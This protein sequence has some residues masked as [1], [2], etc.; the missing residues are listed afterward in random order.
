MLGK[1]HQWLY[2]FLYLREASILWINIFSYRTVWHSVILLLFHLKILVTRVYDWPTE[3]NDQLQKWLND[4]WNNVGLFLQFYFVVFH[5]VSFLAMSVVY[6]L[7]RTLILFTWCW[8]KFHRSYNQVLVSCIVLYLTI[9]NNITIQKEWQPIILSFD[10]FFSISLAESPPRD[11]QITASCIICFP[12]NNILL[13]RSCT[14][15]VRETGISLSWV[16][17]E[18]SHLSVASS[19]PAFGFGK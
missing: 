3:I 16:V 12:T 19:R 15:A 18:L 5:S 1:T 17:R 10:V 4:I 6:S 7:I 2:V 9:M 8:H 11:L 13:M 14:Y